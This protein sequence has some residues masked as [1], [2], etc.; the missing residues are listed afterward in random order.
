[1]VYEAVVTTECRLTHACTRSRYQGRFLRFV[2]FWVEFSH[3]ARAP[4]RLMRQPF[5]RAHFKSSQTC[6]IM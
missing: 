5:D 6:V 2:A 1:M 3:T 4:W